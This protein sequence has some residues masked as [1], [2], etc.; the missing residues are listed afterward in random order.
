MDLHEQHKGWVF[1]FEDVNKVPHLPNYNE[2][3]KQIEEHS[4]RFVEEVVCEYD[5]QYSF[6]TIKLSYRDYLQEKMLRDYH[7]SNARKMDSN[8]YG[9]WKKKN[10]EYLDKKTGKITGGKSINT[11]TF[12]FSINEQDEIT[13]IAFLHRDWENKNGKKFIQSK[14]DLEEIINYGKDTNEQITITD[15]LFVNYE[16]NTKSSNYY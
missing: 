13:Q 6:G 2:L 8:E 10:K 1:Y 5:E 16:A 4:W 11:A 3:F 15:E 14:N 12:F 7:L 9:V